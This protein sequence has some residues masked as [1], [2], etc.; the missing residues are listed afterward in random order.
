MIFVGYGMGVVGL[1]CWIMTLIKMFGDTQDGGTLKGV[2][3]ILC[4]LWAFIWGWMTAAKHA[5][6]NIML[7][8]TI[9]I[10]IQIVVNVMIVGA[11]AASAAK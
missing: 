11:V 7:V 1:V 5:T 10:A 6:K 4:P 2:L 8:W 9:A 3:G